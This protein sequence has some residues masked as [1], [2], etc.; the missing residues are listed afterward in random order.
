MADSSQ[1]SSSDGEEQ[2]PFKICGFF[3]L[4]VPREEEEEH[5]KG[6]GRQGMESSPICLAT[7]CVTD[8]NGFVFT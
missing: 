1:S 6:R 3:R 8:V 2:K 7:C 5:I 4:D